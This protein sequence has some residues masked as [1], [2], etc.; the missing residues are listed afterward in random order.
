MQRTHIDHWFHG[1]HI[2]FFD[3]GSLARLAVVRNLRVFMHAPSD[4]MPHIIA[5]YRISVGLGVRLYRE[6]DIAQMFS[7]PALFYRQRQAFFGHANQLQSIFAYI[8]DRNG[9]GRVTYESVQRHAHVDRKNVTFLQF[10]I[11][12]KAVD[13]LFIYRRA[14]RIG[15]TVVTLERWVRA[16]VTNQLLGGVIYFQR[17]HSRFDHGAQGLQDASDQ[18]ARGAH[19][20]NLFLRLPN[21]HALPDGA[22]TRGPTLLVRHD[23]VQRGINLFRIFVPLDDSKPARSLVIIDHRRGLSFVS[24][25]T[26]LNLVRTII[27]PLLKLHLVSIA[28]VV[29]LR[30]LEINVVGFV[31]DR[32]I[33]AAGQPFFQNAHR[34]IDQNRRQC[35]SLRRHQLLEPFS[36]HRGTRKPIKHVA[37]AAIVCRGALSHHLDHNVVGYQ[38][39]GSLRRVDVFGGQGPQ[40]VTSRYLWQTQSLL[41]QTRLRALAGTRRPHQHN[42]L[43]HCGQA[44][45]P[46][47][48]PPPPRKPS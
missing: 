18:L 14:N 27:R 39:S 6:T 9:R 48:L 22:L 4:T 8:A 23:V 35:I 47:S 36:L 46:R 12:R 24:L 11:G 10:V 7:R 33:S 41:N 45:R 5:D 32:T 1:K 38:P 31:S 16:R 26:H 29:R 44:R 42:N 43:C 40:H 3:L 17:R 13:D 30:R 2:A 15:E 37:I 25:Q 20:I 34:H 19:L 21:N 28:K